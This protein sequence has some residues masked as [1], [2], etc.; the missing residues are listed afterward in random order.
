LQVETVESDA[1]KAASQDTSDVR[2]VISKVVDDL[3][4]YVEIKELAPSLIKDDDYD[5]TEELPVQINKVPSV[6][7]HLSVMKRSQKKRSRVDAELIRLSC[8]IVNVEVEKED[9]EEKKQCTKPFC[10]L[11]CVC[12]SLRC[13]NTLIFH[14]QNEK[15]MFS[16]NC[17]KER[18]PTYEHRV[19]LPAGTNVLSSDT[20]TKIEDEAK[21]HLARMEREFTQTIIQTNNR[22]IVVGA[23]GRSKTRRAAQLPKKYTDYVENI[24]EDDVTDKQVDFTKRCVVSLTRLNLDAVIPFCMQHNNYDC[25]C[26]GLSDYVPKDHPR[27]RTSLGAN[28]PASAKKTA[29]SQ[30]V[31]KAKAR[32][33]SNENVADHNLSEPVSKKRAVSD[34]DVTTKHSA[35]AAEDEPNAESS[36]SL[37]GETTAAAESDS[38]TSSRPVRNKKAKKSELFEYSLDPDVETCARTMEVKRRR[39]SNTNISID[40]FESALRNDFVYNYTQ[41]DL[42]KIKM[43]HAQR[44]RY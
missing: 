39:K 3:I 33:R 17:P 10:Q 41:A 15:C 7:E 20:V 24:D 29:G 19:T 6:D 1:Q 38:P 12:K 2:T 23:S 42:L 44:K 27:V 34:T 18:Q 28:S 5:F 40:N 30:I 11:G 14:C 36:L 21:K 13:E 8:K 25:F 9:D 37:S 22:T 26:R 4:S 32:K 43:N 16:C 31:D 35:D